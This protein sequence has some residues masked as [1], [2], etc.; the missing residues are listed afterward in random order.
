MLLILVATLAALA[1]AQSTP[2]PKFGNWTEEFNGYPYILSGPMTLGKKT[3]FEIERCHYVLRLLDERT[4]APARQVPLPT[5]ASRCMDILVQRKSALG[6]QAFLEIFSEDIED[7]KRFWYDINFNSTLHDPATWKAVECRALVPLPNV[8]AWAFSTWSASPFADA[9]NN[10]GNAEHYFKNSSQSGGGAGAA[11]TSRILEGWG[12]VLTNFSIPNYSA[13]TCAQRPMVRPLPEFR[14]KACG[15]KNLVDD[16]DTNFGVLQIAARDVNVAGAR[17][18][19]IYASVWYGSGIS[20]EH[21][22][23]ERQHIIIEIVNLSLKAQE[24][25]QSGRFRVPAPPAS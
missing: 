18:V 22:E 6:D 17:Y 25:I 1:A 24:D 7:A 10:R 2:W 15:D 12:G 9:A 3:D 5:P 4:H 20:E 16:K 13:R 11:A 21:M 14:L 23:A 19:D 8:N